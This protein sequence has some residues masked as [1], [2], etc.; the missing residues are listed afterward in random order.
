MHM[1][2]P[3]NAHMYASA[4]NLRDGGGHG[5]RERSLV[6]VECSVVVED[7]ERGRGAGKSRAMGAATAGSC[8][9]LAM[10]RPRLWTVERGR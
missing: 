2:A 10:A 6:G 5:Q 4:L 1:H 8:A 7:G 9:G 3:A